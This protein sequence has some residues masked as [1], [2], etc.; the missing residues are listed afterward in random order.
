MGCLLGMCVG[1]VAGDERSGV[2]QADAGNGGERYGWFGCLDHRSTYGEGP[3]PEPFLVDDTNLETDE[4]RLDYLHT[5]GPGRRDE[6]A[7]AEVEKGFGLLTLELEVAYEKSRDGGQSEQGLGNLSLG[8][9]HPVYQWVSADEWVNM[10]FGVGVEFGIPS[11]STVGRNGEF[12]PRI[13]NDLSLGRHFT[14]Q[15]VLG[16][17]RLYG[18]GEDG[19]L[20]TLEYGLVFGYS[21]SHR[22]LPVP[23]V[24]QL[25]PVFELSGETALNHQQ[26]GDHSLTGNLALRAN[27]DPIGEVQPRIGV[28]YV[29][30]LDHG[31]RQDLSS[32]FIL[33]LVFEY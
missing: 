18:S 21:L 22:D 24:R 7:R 31:A 2:G 16:F 12:A 6:Y 4:F 23:G 30:P 29:F 27:L 19:G 13:F 25:V 14:L 8:L 32:G 17:S 20:Q 26:S 10:T 9:R 11:G 33:S 15:S 5:R 1:A 3:Y 28:G